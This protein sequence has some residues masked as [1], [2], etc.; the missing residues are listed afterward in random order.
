[1]LATGLPDGVILSPNG[2]YVYEGRAYVP[3]RYRHQVLH[4]FHGHVTA[5]HPGETRMLKAVKQVFAWPKMRED[6]QGW[7]RGCIRCNRVKNGRERLQGPC[8]VNPIKGPFRAIH[9]DYFH[10]GQK[11][12]MTMIDRA[13]RWV[14]AAIVPD[15]SAAVAVSTLMH[16]WISRFGVPDY[17]VSDNEKS[18]TSEFMRQLYAELGIKGCTTMIYHPQG[19]SP[20]ESFHR[21]LRTELNSSELQHLGAQE[22]LDTILMA[23]R[24]SYHTSLRDTPAFLTFGH[25]LSFPVI[26]QYAVDP[27]DSNEERSALFAKVRRELFWESW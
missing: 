11:T 14:E 18:F 23:Y 20:I 22:Y 27:Q 24:A 7:I 12:I 19:N 15:R 17:I 26:R 2:L 21:L 3:P 9:I 13:T 6:I 1:C 25:D 8:R 16:Y 4:H 5:G 10:L